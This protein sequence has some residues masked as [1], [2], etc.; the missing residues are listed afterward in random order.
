MLPSEHTKLIGTILDEAELEII[1]V[2]SDS[3]VRVWSLKDGCCS[4]SYFLEQ[5]TTAKRFKTKKRKITHVCPDKDV[6]FLA[7]IY[8]KGY[9]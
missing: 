8:E 1:T 7:V 3:L 5:K 9:I 2:D 4:R 6:R